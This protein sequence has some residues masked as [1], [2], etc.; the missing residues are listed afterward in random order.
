MVLSLLTFWGVG[1]TSG[2]LLGFP[3]G[4]GGVGL[5]A[6][7]SIGVAIAGVIFV[8]RFHKL[9]AQSGYFSSKRGDY[10]PNHR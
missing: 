10:P 5:W 2:Y 7:Q 1:L 4:L 8:W 3:F 9:T 6:G